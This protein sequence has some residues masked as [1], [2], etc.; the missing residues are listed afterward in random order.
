MDKKDQRILLEL[1][2]NA[3]ASHKEIGKKV[4]LSKS[5]VARRI[6]RLEEE[7]IILDYVT[8]IDT[9][10]LGFTTYDIYFKY[11]NTTPEKEEEI[12]QYLISHKKVWLVVS[13]TGSVDLAILISTKTATEYYE[14]WQEI[15][16]HIKSWVRIVRTSILLEHLHYTR[17]YLLPDE[18]QEK[19]EIYVGKLG[20]E[21]IDTKDQLIL[22]LLSRNAKAHIVDIAKETSLSAPGVI[23]RI[24]RL[25]TKQIIQ[26]YR[27]NINFQKI[28]YEYFKVFITLSELSQ[29]KRMLTWLKQQ[30]GLVYTEGFIG[31]CDVEFDLEIKD[32]ECFVAFLSGM[33]REFGQYI[34]L[35]DYFTLLRLHKSTYYPE[36]I[37]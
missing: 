9:M 32:V 26:G 10:R 35:I 16:A 6:Q 37:G 22:K 1:D 31:G 21:T 24:R 12:I 36:E 30:P 19:K 17:N 14:L 13:A 18:N 25:E 4:K 28:G 11:T 2:Q 27:A 34:E 29:R 15:Y 8:I 3:R 20:N 33:K 23:Q 5:A 7:Q